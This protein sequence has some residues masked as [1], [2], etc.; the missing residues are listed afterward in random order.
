MAFFVFPFPTFCSSQNLEII[1]NADGADFFDS[2]HKS[3]CQKSGVLT[4]KLDDRT[5]V[6]NKQPPNKQIWLSSP[7]SGPKRFDWIFNGNASDEGSGE[8]VYA[9][10]GTTM[11]EI[12]CAEVGIGYDVPQ[13]EA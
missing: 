6:I 8:W 2:F 9:R 13:D 1:K 5:Y 11:N 12:L 7:I 4:L 10:D 3:S